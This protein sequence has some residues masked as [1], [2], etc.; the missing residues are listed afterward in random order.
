MHKA[1]AAMRRIEEVLTT[2]PEIAEAPGAIDPRPSAA[3][4]PSRT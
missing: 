3:P 1:L 2:E 4:W